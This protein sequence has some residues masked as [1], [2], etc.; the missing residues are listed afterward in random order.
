MVALNPEVYIYTY[1]DLLHSVIG[2]R[3]S[4]PTKIKTRHQPTQTILKLHLIKIK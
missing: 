4:S 1:M 2:R 3:Y